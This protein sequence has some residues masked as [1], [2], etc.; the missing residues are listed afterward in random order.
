MCNVMFT[1]MHVVHV[2]HA[3]G[4]MTCNM[5][6]CD[7]ALCDVMSYGM[8]LNDVLGCIVV[9]CIVTSCVAKSCAHVLYVTHACRQWLHEVV[10]FVNGMQCNV[11]IHVMHAC[12]VMRVSQSCAR[13]M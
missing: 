12:D 9:P 1:C 4:A 10:V 5:M 2:M 3:C 11:C 7:A 8:I 6:Q 13:V